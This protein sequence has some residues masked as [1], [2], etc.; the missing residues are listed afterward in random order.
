MTVFLNFVQKLF[1]N[2]KLH[3]FA[4][5]ALVLTA[6]TLLAT[7]FVSESTVVLLRKLM[8][9][10]VS[11]EVTDYYLRKLNFFVYTLLFAGLF[12]LA[13]SCFSCYCSKLYGKLSG[14][15]REEGFTEKSGTFLLFS[16]WMGIFF[17]TESYL[18]SNF[19][20]DT[21][22]LIC[23]ISSTPWSSLVTQTLPE[24]QSAPPGVL[25]FI[26]LLGETAGFKEQLLTFPVF[27]AGVLSLFIFY[28]LLRELFSPKTRAVI[29]FLFAFNASAVFYAGELKQ[30][31]FDLFFCIL[32]L[33]QT[34][35]LLKDDAAKVTPG[36]ILSGVAAVFFSHA[37]F[38]L[39]STFGA[40]LFFQSLVK[41]KHRLPGVIL[42]D[43]FW[44]LAVLGA[45]LL[46]LKTMP[47]GMYSYHAPFF[48]P[49]PFDG[50]SL[51]WYRELFKN[52][53]AFPC[54]LSLNLL[55]PA[56]AAAICILAGIFFQWKNSKWLCLCGVTPVFLMF[57]ASFCKSYPIDSAN[58]AAAARFLLFTVPLFYLF[59]GAVL[60]QLLRR[61]VLLFGIAAS[62][63]GAAATCILLF[64][65]P[66][67]WNIR[68]L[69]AE[70]SDTLDS[71]VPLF[72]NYGSSVSLRGYG[73]NKLF[74]HSK[75]LPESG[76]ETL[77]W[78]KARK[79]LPREGNYRI[80]ICQVKYAKQLEEK[81]R[82]KC[83]VTKK[84]RAGGTVFEVSSKN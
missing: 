76:L 80:F 72:I 12:P 41:A 73:Y 20:N 35:H 40:I 78:E 13:K 29:L 45:A 70:L 48:A 57:A 1:S 59:T 3:L 66:I 22:A 81:L 42:L 36:V 75:R 37:S 15:L 56:G 38:L 61:K 53:F 21:F 27:I 2:R 11:G 68:P 84:E 47:R 14:W 69:C 65:F 17:R 25:V 83:Q 4:G 50:A 9:R 39:L 67:Y 55:L 34:V 51:L 46:A 24:M 62:Y 82:E 28:K 23:A 54:S 64:S 10:P 63:F 26:K 30:Y 43:V 8:N 31:G 16:F 5:G 19:W 60:E 79:V 33:Y 49:L 44:A 52:L 71:K 58:N 7:N 18:C 74:E 32:L 6:V 77:D